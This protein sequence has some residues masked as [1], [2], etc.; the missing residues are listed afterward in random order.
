MDQMQL[1]N[2]KYALAWKCTLSAVLLGVVFM[3]FPISMPILKLKSTFLNLAPEIFFILGAQLVLLTLRWLHILRA[4]GLK[5]SFFGALTMYWTGLFFNQC[6]P[7]TVGGDVI[8]I[9]LVRKSKGTF[10]QGTAAILFERASG[11]LLLSL[12]GLVA[13]ILAPHE[14]MRVQITL[15]FSIFFSVVV[16]LIGVYYFPKKYLRKFE[17]IEN[18]S[19]DLALILKVFVKNAP[20]LIS[21]LSIS[22]ICQIIE[23]YAFYLCLNELG[24]E[25]SLSQVFSI[26]SLVMFAAAIP[27]SLSGWGM[28]EVSSIAAFSSVGVS[29]EISV[30]S[31]IIF[32]LYLLLFSLPGL[33][34][35]ISNSVDSFAPL[36]FFGR[37]EKK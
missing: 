18:V 31:G 16:A 9:A 5:V 11:V 12:I 33:Y 7:S 22:G 20:L 36:K 25:V 2:R 14:T 4:M 15:I 28:R 21:I 1:K 30:I 6:L 27:V 32:G 3:Y 29:G 13:A 17:F 10:H 35:T 8:K 19:K 37:Q 23:L 34:F 26:G 24:A